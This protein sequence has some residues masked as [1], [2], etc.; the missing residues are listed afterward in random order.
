MTSRGRSSRLRRRWALELL[1][2]DV[3]GAKFEAG[4]EVG[5]GAVVI[6]ASLAC[7]AQAAGIP[8]NRCG[9]ACGSDSDSSRSA[10]GSCSFRKSVNAKVDPVPGDWGCSAMN[11]RKDDSSERH[12][13]AVAAGC[14]AASL[15]AAPERQRKP[16]AGRVRRRVRTGGGRRG[17]RIP[18]QF[19]TA[20]KAPP[21]GGFSVSFP[22]RGRVRWKL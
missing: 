18:C 5:D 6:T 14:A 15:A 1:D 8:G 7:A 12:F 16:A 3:A 4:A 17:E 21:D 13:Q 9:T 10:G 20:S 2:H 19:T 11:A 22:A